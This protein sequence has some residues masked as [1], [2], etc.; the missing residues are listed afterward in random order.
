MRS[1]GG[2]ETML[3]DKTFLFWKPTSVKNRNDQIYSSVYVSTKTLQANPRLHYNLTVVFASIIFRRQQIRPIVVNILLF[4]LSAVGACKKRWKTLRDQLSHTLKAE[5][6]KKRSGS[7]AGTKNKRTSTRSS[8]IPS[9][10]FLSSFRI[11]PS[12]ALA[13][14]IPV[15][16]R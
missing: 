15:H 14:E 11:R 4:L 8:V 1:H 10:L 16:N 7:A 5:K 13:K 6:E 9:S 12:F 2:V 3:E